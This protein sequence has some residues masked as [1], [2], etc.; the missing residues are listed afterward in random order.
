MNRLQ[1]CSLIATAVIS[2]LL[3]SLACLG[4][5]LTHNLFYLFSLGRCLYTL[6]FTVYYLTKL[7]Q[8]LPTREIHIVVL[9]ISEPNPDPL[10]AKVMERM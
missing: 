6:L 7:N 9:Q 10:L 4:L 1:C 5:R 8:Q 2:G 3:L